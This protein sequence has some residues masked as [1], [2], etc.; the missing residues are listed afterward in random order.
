M[1]GAERKEMGWWV[2]RAVI[3]WLVDLSR[4]EVRWVRQ[5]GLSDVFAV[6]IG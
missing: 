1:F 4:R 5:F 3:R 2:F 6:Q